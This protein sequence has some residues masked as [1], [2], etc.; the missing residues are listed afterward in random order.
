MSIALDKLADSILVAMEYISTLK[1][2]FITP[3]IQQ[4]NAAKTVLSHS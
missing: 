1:F 4:F 2:T 3:H